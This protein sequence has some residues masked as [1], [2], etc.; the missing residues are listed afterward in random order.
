[1]FKMTSNFYPAEEPKNGYIGK[2]DLTIAEAI[3]INGIS[4]FENNGVIGMRL[5]EYERRD[6]GLRESYVIPKSTEVYAS[7][8]KTIEMA[9]KDEKYHFGHVNG[10]YNPFISV[11][12]KKV[13]EPYA[14]GRFSIDIE[15]TC[16]LYGVKTRI[17][18]AEKEPFVAVDMPT[19]SKYTNS[20]NEVVYKPAFEG[21]TYKHMRDGK[22]EYKHFDTLIKNLV[23]AEREKVHSNERT[24]FDDKLKDASKEAEKRN[25]AR[26]AGQSKDSRELVH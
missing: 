22:E 17:R 10:K 19:I 12:G 23:R 6:N 13:D 3:R 5:P 1:M 9:V 2:A 25:S 24:S 26:A 14:D 4:V 15:N 21:L 18:N 11:S 8:L 20:E 16:T 7:M